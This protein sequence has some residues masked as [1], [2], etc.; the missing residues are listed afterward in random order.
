MVNVKKDS[1]GVRDGVAVRAIFIINDIME[2]VLV[3]DE[4]SRPREPLHSRFRYGGGDTHIPPADYGRMLKM[5]GAILG[6]PRKKAR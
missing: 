2:V 6:K 1:V 5:A 3:L 4:N